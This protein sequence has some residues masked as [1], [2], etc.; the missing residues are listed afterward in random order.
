[1]ACPEKR[2]KNKKSAHLST[3]NAKT[4]THQKNFFM[5]IGKNSIP[6]LESS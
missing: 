4:N 6:Y 2:I 3:K 1:M 5:M